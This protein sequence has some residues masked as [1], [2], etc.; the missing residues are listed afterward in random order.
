MSA[1]AAG[2]QVDSN[3]SLPPCLRVHAEQLEA[4]FLSTD[5][6]VHALGVQ[7]IEA[8]YDQADQVAGRP[9]V[10][11]TLCQWAIRGTICMTSYVMTTGS[12]ETDGAENPIGTSMMRSSRE[13]VPGHVAHPSYCEYERTQL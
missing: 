13:L 1:E 5:P 11:K 9:G 3:Q 10:R 2:R 4:S 8:L 12:M 7:G 6:A